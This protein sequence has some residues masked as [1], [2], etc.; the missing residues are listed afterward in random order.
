M[1]NLWK[2]D[3]F[4]TLYILAF[5]VVLWIVAFKLGWKYLVQEKRCTAK[6][7]GTVVRYTYYT[8]GEGVCLPIVEYYVHNKP[9]RVRGPEFRSYKIKNLTDFAQGMTEH[10]YRYNPES[11][12]F[13]QTVKSNPFFKVVLNPM[14]KMF[15]KNLE[16]DV[17][18][19]PKN[20]KLAY[21]IRYCNRKFMFWIPFLCG[22]GM[23]PFVMLLQYIFMR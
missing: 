18:Y 19:D 21:V 23:V 2:L 13:E 20:P 11:D 1:G 4:W 3:L 16:V 14:A 15:P 12:G 22:A 6:T 8:V 9:Y 7:K 10:Q 17:Y 5:V